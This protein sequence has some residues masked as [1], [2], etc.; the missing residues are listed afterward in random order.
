[1]QPQTVPHLVEIMIFEIFES[2]LS[3]LFG[4]RLQYLWSMQEII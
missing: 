2:P 1:M 4:F 3:K